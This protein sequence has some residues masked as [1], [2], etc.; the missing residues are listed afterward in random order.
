DVTLFERTETLG[1]HLVEASVPEFKA[2]IRRLLDWYRRQLDK[3]G[4]RVELGTTVTPKLV[5][6]R[7]PDAVVVATGSV[8]VVPKIP[9]VDNAMVATCCDLLLGKKECGNHVV[10]IG[11]GLEGCETALWLSSQG[12]R[13]I[14]VEMQSEVAA[15]IHRANRAMLLDLLMD[16]GVRILTNTMLHEVGGGAI[17]VVSRDLRV[18]RIECDT[19]ALGVGMKPNQDLYQSLI[20]EVYEVYLIGDAKQ[21]RRIHDAI[22]EGWNIGRAL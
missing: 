6:D 3:L 18:E 13:V 17:T 21:P 11:G 15:D 1:G 16:A 2:D 20:G 8:P 14:I 19:V 22:W 9:G 12:K 4:I 10:V 5:T 7:D